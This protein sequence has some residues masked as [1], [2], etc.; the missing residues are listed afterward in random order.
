MLSGI[1]SVR[2]MLGGLYAAFGLV[3][4]LEV[5]LPLVDNVTAAPADKHNAAVDPAPQAI[6]PPEAALDDS[7]HT[8]LERPLFAPDRRAIAEQAAG[9][10]QAAAP[11]PPPL[12]DRLAGVMLGPDE[13][14]ALFSS[15]GQKPVAVAVGG[16]IGG[17]TVS[18]I[19]LD[20]VVLTSAFG[21]RVLAPAHDGH[22]DA[23]A[24]PR[25][26][27]PPALPAAQSSPPPAAASPR[28]QSRPLQQ[29]NLLPPAPGTR[30]ASPHP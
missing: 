28:L 2:T 5:I 24:V 21:E 10:Q 30:Q 20:R 12:P 9:E 29:R 27:A 8:I 23:A 3:I 19:E 25:V 17:W 6:A 4:A 22:I 11:T 18:T 13:R 26:P 7:I 15:P 1:R 14:E 16:A